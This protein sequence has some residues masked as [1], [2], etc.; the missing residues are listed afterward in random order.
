[1][2]ALTAGSRLEALAV[3]PSEA[4]PGR[5][6]DMFIAHL[7]KKHRL[8]MRSLLLENMHVGYKTIQKLSSYFPHLE[9]FSISVGTS[10]LAHMSIL[11]AL[12]LNLR[13][14]YLQVP[15]TKGQVE[16]RFEYEEALAL[17]QQG[18]PKLRRIQVNYNVW[19]GEWATLPLIEGGVSVY[20]ALR[21]E[22]LGGPDD[23]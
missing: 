15:R 13:V 3:F 6:A 11:I 4:L 17:M 14:L 19:V 2:E 22:R 21:R 1:V 12:S 23:H 8:T 10:I 5:R 20:L 16:P 18:P 9:E 7:S